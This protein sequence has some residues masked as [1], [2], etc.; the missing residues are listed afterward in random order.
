MTE[1]VLYVSDYQVF[2]LSEEVFKEASLLRSRGVAQVEEAASSAQ[3][4]QGIGHRV[5][6]T[7]LFVS[8]SCRF[9]SPKNFFQDGIVPGSIAYCVFSLEEVFR[10]QR[11]GDE[12][13]VIHKDEVLAQSQ[14]AP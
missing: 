9:E 11:G 14:Y 8:F 10:R 2:M 6:E 5:L 4:V 13:V 7:D 12:E 3:D 1:L